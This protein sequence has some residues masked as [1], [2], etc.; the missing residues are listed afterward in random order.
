MKQV[1]WD[2]AFLILKKWQSRESWVVAGE[3]ERWTTQG[4]TTSIFRGIPARIFDADP[5]M[6]Y[7]KLGDE[8][9]FALVGASFKFSDFENTPFAAGNLGP[10]KFESQLEAVFP[11]S[12]LLVFAKLWDAER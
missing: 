9:E 2:E 10:D 11:D 6:G 8:R 5:S 3:V 4:E 1:S 7:V 12:H